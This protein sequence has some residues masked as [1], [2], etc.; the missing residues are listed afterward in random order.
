MAKGC[1]LSH[2]PT[3][4][5]KIKGLSAFAQRDREELEVV[6]EREENR[7]IYTLDC[8]IIQLCEINKCFDMYILLHKS[9]TYT[10]IPQ[11]LEYA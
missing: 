5:T 10:S 4:E 9:H 3:K 8:Y 11:L 2:F 7:S 1:L 6:S